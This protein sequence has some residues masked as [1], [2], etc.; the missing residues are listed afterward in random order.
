MTLSVNSYNSLGINRLDLGRHVPCPQ[1]YAGFIKQ[2][3]LRERG[4]NEYIVL[5]SAQRT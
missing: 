1:S 4:Q 3:Y 5:L 2:H